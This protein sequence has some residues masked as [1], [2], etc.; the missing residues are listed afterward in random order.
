MTSNPPVKLKW[1]EHLNASWVSEDGDTLASREGVTR[2]YDRLLTS[3]EVVI[4]PQQVL[5]LKVSFYLSLLGLA[6]GRLGNVWVCFNLVSERYIFILIY[7]ILCYV[8]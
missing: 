5:H 7:L 3:Q 8:F 1:L 6:K 2:L 4:M